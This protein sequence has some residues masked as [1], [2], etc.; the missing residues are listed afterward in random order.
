[1]AHGCGD[2]IPALLAMSRRI[3]NRFRPSSLGP[4]PSGILSLCPKRAQVREGALQGAAGTSS[5]SRVPVELG[6]GPGV[7]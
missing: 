1:M 2:I 3:K 7:K 4:T 6:P 5:F